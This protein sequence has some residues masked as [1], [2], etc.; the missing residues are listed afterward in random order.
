MASLARVEAHKDRE[1]VITDPLHQLKLN[2]R[3]SKY[4]LYHVFSLL[5]RGPHFIRG[6]DVAPYHHSQSARSVMSGRKDTDRY[7]TLH[8]SLVY[9]SFGINIL[10]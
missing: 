8:F 2:L 4:H 10:V 6:L 5:V 7:R 3:V 9:L 1:K